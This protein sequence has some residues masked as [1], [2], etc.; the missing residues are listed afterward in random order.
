MKKTFWYKDN[1]SGA[2]LSF[3]TLREAADAAKKEDGNYI[4]VFD[5]NGKRIVEVKATGYTYP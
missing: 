2:I 1:W 3:P 5:S 4:T